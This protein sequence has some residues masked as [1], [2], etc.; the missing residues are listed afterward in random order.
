M[1]LTKWR[2]T[3]ITTESSDSQGDL[4]QSMQNT[5]DIEIIFINKNLSHSRHIE[6]IINQSKKI[7][8]VN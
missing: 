1:H 2:K 3:K 6:T 4:N 7:P 8:S 5:Y